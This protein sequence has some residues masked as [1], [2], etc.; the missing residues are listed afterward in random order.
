VPTVAFDIGCGDEVVQPVA[1]DF[2]E[3]GGD[4]GCEIEVSDLE[5]AEV[6]EL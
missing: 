4:D 2:T 5:G 6:V 3:E 1:S